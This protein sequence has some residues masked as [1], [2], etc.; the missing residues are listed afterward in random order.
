M[1][2]HKLREIFTRF[3]AA[4]PH[5]TTEL[6]YSSPFELLIAVILSAQATDKGVNLATRKLFPKANTPEK[7]LAL[8]EAGL[9]DYIKSIGLYKTKAKNILATCSHAYSASWGGGSA[10]ARTT[11]K[12]ARS[13]PQDRQCNV[14]HCI[15]RTYHCGGYAYFPCFKPNRHCTRKNRAGGGEETPGMY[16]RRN[17]GTMLITGLFCTG[18]M[19]A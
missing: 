8:G 13:W 9:R 3:K 10:G 7:I 18:V 14:E 2:A 19:C 12:T 15:R 1:N 11:G 6:E 4:N 5:P 16:Y 17:F